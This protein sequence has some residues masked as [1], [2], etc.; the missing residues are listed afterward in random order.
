MWKSSEGFE[1]VNIYG[2]HCNTSNVASFFLI[3]ALKARGLSLEPPPPPR[4]SLVLRGGGEKKRFGFFPCYLRCVV[5]EKKI[6]SDKCNNVQMRN[7]NKT[8]ANKCHKCYTANV[9]RLIVVNSH[10]SNYVHFLFL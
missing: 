6:N 7:E 1:G 2:R 8:H 10:S 9:V 5:A 3:R 4:N